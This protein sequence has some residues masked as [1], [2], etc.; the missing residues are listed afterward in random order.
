VAEHPTEQFVV[1]LGDIGVSPHWLVTPSGTAP[2][3]GAQW[4]VVDQSRTESKIPTWAI[5]CAVVG[6]LLCLLGL[7]L[8]LVKEDVT[9]GFIQVSVRAGTLT[10]TTHLPVSTP[11][12]IAQIHGLVAHAQMMSAQAS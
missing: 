1:T 11:G 2:L 9:T 10:H 7:L 3:A 8:L 12:Q 4:F 5:V 6:A